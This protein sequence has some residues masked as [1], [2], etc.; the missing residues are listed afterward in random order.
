VTVGLVERL[1]PATVMNIS[2]T[3]RLLF[4]ESKMSILSRQKDESAAI[5]ENTDVPLS[6]GTGNKDQE[7][8]TAPTLQN[9]PSLPQ[10]RKKKVF[11]IKQQLAEST[12][13]LDKRLDAVL[14]RLLVAVTT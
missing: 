12:Y 6:E 4:K 2:P 8:M 10:I 11:A 14:E 13:N 9:S 5:I 7:G 3:C 1:L